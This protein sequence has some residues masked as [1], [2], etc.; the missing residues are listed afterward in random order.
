MLAVMTEADMQKQERQ[1]WLGVSPS[2]ALPFCG[3][4]AG[5]GETLLH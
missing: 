2:M 4:M 3:V 1:V 5:C